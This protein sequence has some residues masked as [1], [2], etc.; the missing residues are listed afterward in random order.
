[1]CIKGLRMEDLH[2]QIDCIMA[3]LINYCK[4][5]LTIT[6][7]NAKKKKKKN[8]KPKICFLFLML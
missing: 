5:K 1:M 7:A 8:E 4:E 6:Q 2:R 3:N